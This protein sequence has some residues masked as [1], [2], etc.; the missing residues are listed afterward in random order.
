[1]GSLQKSPGW[2]KGRGKGRSIAERGA[3]ET[4][5]CRGLVPVV[6]PSSGVPRVKVR[7]LK[8][9]SETSNQEKAHQPSNRQ[10]MRAGSHLA[11]SALVLSLAEALGASVVGGTGAVPSRVAGSVVLVS[12]TP[13]EFESN[14]SRR[15][16]KRT[17]KAKTQKANLPENLLT[18]PRL[19]VVLD[20]KLV[21]QLGCLLLTL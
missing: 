5:L 14:I 13:R 20:T 3:C 15:T 8:N 16:P 12:G 18:N 19:H 7:S 21:L 6:V 1:M 11:A 17:L 4:S 9:Q 2:W 10:Q